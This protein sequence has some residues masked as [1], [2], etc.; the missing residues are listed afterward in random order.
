[1][2]ARPR[3]D[4][5]LPALPQAYKD[6]WDK[7]PWPVNRDGMVTPKASGGSTSV[8]GLGGPVPGQPVSSRDPRDVELRNV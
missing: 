8:G 6:E 7:R 3:N 5:L 1:M 2:R 4:R